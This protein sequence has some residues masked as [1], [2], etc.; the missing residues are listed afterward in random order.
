MVVGGL[1]EDNAKTGG[2]PKKLA[3]LVARKAGLV[4]SVVAPAPAEEL[5]RHKVMVDG[6]PAGLTMLL[7]YTY[8][9]RSWAIATP[10]ST[11][12]AELQPTVHVDSVDSRY[13]A[14]SQAERCEGESPDA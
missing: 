7:T 11:R 5:A 9:R 4:E 12:L 14:R 8:E 6:C 1:V 2:V 3:L 13:T 10:L